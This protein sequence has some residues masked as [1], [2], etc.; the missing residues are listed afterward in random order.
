MPFDIVGKGDH[1]EISAVGMAVQS[2]ALHI[3][4]LLY[5]AGADMDLAAASFGPLTYDSF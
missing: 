1:N 3:L 4:D 2:E 5:R